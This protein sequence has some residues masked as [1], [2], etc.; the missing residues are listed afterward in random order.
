MKKDLLIRGLIFLL[1]CEV[2]AQQFAVIGD[3]GTDDEYEAQVASLVK[4]WNPEF[5]LTLGDNNY[6]QGSASTIDRNIGK[7]YSA[8]IYPYRGEYGRGAQQNK[9]FPSTGNH[10]Y[11]TKDARPYYDY[12][13]LPGNERYYDFVRGN[14][15]F[16]SLNSN[17]QERDGIGATSRQAQWLQQKLT[18]S[19]AR[20]KIVYFHHAPYSSGE[21]GSNPR[22][23]WPFK[24]WGA[25]V[26]IS[27]HNHIY[28]RLLVD[29]L[30]Y[31]VSGAGGRDLDQFSRGPLPQTKL[32]D[33]R[34]HGALRVKAT[35]Q[36][37][38]F[39]YRYADGKLV[40]TYTI[41]DEEL[42][43][44]PDQSARL[45][46]TIN[47]S[48]A[49]VEQRKKD[50]VLYATSSDLELGFDDYRNQGFQTIGLRYADL[51]VPR[52]SVIQEAYVV[53]KAKGTSTGSCRV[54][55][56]GERTGHSEP[57]TLSVNY[58]LTNRSATRA[59]VDWSPENWPRADQPESSPNLK[60]IVQEL[61]DHPDWSSGQAITLMIEGIA[62][63]RRAW[64]YDGK[65][66][67]KNAPRLVIRYVAK[68]SAASRSSSTESNEPTSE[69]IRT[70]DLSPDNSISVYPNPVANAHELT[71]RLGEN[72]P[73]QRATAKLVDAQGKLLR[74]E[75]IEF[76]RRQAT[77][78][79][80]PEPLL[81]TGVYFLEIGDG[82]YRE[83][84]RI[85]VEK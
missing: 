10:D 47:R 78:S 83:R 7:Y 63:T 33:N 18:S 29:S 14:V 4:S 27:G 43:E 69:G 9:F 85:I 55:F 37:L 8:F 66:A 36:R 81:P 65:E 26:V 5:I 50:G 11:Y 20:W 38:T 49:D 74:E 72:V 16:F 59:V 41:K 82:T 80:P 52:N 61:V 1:A 48:E 71:I 45:T 64:S 75:R 2:N 42:P 56:V 32:R 35:N 12:F 3:F 15:H 77:F 70:Q 54:R 22:L 6:P 58:S 25:S 84:A 24:A 40:D 51:T 31:F 28:E 53:F 46:R 62:G 57:Y 30:P 19:T 68:G 60:S 67:G 21:H 17:P 39:E 23:Q 76:T 44:V 34:Q 73:W 13:T 79:L